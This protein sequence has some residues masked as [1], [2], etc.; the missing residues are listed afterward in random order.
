MAVM[1]NYVWMILDWDPF[2]WAG[3][4]EEAR[5]EVDKLQEQKMVE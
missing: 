4:L 2:Y 1:S 3:F 5:D